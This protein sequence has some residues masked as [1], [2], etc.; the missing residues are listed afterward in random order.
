MK[1]FFEAGTVSAADESF[2]AKYSLA[3]EALQAG[4]RPSS[5]RELNE[6]QELQDW[7]E[8]GEPEPPPKRR[9]A[10]DGSSKGVKPII[11][12]WDEWALAFQSEPVTIDYGRQVPDD[13]PTTQDLISSGVRLHMAAQPEPL[14]AETVRSTVGASPDRE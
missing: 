9:R 6:L 1:L 5:S 13:A 2:A 4:R 12:E 11:M 3:S 14:E 8:M 7:H 10:D